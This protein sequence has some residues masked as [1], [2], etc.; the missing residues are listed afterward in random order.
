VAGAG[1]TL[2]MI[3]AYRLAGELSAAAGDHRVAFRRYQ[4]GYRETIKR[5]Q[6]VGPD[7]RLLA[8]KNRVGML[9]RNTVARLPVLESMAGMERILQPKQTEPLPDYPRE[10]D[11]A[12]A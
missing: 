2:A 8:P 3:G 6:Q 7:L 4:E 12:R 5:K 9:V 1:A 11:A 10:R